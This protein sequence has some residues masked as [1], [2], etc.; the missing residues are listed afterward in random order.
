MNK[1]RAEEREEKPTGA[2]ELK[3]SRLRAGGG[4]SWKPQPP[5]RGNPRD[6]AQS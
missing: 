3:G 6:T 4:E 1:Y 5:A 2:W